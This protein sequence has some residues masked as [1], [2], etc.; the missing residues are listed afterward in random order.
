MTAGR[1]AAMHPCSFTTDWFSANLPVW[2][3][4]VAPH[5]RRL[6]LPKVLEVGAFEGRAS[7]WFLGGFATLRLTVI[8][9]W[10]YTDGAGEDTFARF[11]GNVLPFRDRLTVLRGKSQLM[12]QLPCDTFDL[13]YI[14]G[15]HTSAAVMHDAVLGHEL[16]KPQGLLI[17]DDYLGGD[18]SVAF[19]KPAID[20]FHAAYGHAGKA[21]L[22]SDGYQRI[23]RKMNP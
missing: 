8:D 15:E 9:P 6:D 22:L 14:D 5:L 12:R 13:I 18:R 19:P 23:Y 4:V 21:V 10:A 20:L 7:V 1:I 16:L 3:R 17:F 11:S 2:E